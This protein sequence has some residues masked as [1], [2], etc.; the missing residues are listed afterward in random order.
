V[1]ARVDD[2]D[3]VAERGEREPTLDSLPPTSSTR[4]PG[5]SDA[6]APKTNGCSTMRSLTSRT[7][8]WPGQCSTATGGLSQRWPW[9]A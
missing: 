3:V 7:P 8:T 5:G 6:S 2:D 4:E 1:R 9:A